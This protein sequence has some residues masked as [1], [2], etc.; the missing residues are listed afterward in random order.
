MKMTILSSDLVSLFSKSIS[1]IFLYALFPINIYLHGISIPPPWVHVPSGA[2]RL[3]PVT[4]A[5]ACDTSPPLINGASLRA[6]GS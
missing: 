6:T 2:G 3:V 4:S 5:D 1:Y